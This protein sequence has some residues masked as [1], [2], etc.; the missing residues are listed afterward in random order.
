MAK[1]VLTQNLSEPL[2]G[3]KTAKVDICPGD[4]N[5]IIDGLTCGEPVLASGTLQYLENQELPARSVTTRDGQAELTLRAAGNVRQTWFRMPW[6]ACNGATEWQVHLNP[7]VPSDIT[8]H[9]DGGNVRLD[10]SGMT[11]TRVSADTGGGNVEVILPGS[12]ANLNVIAKTG[13]GGVTVEVGKAT[14]GSSRIDACSG[15]GNVAV[16]LP[17]G[18]AARIYATSG[19][20][21]VIV[22]PRFS[23]VDKTTYQS[24]DYEVAA[25]R[26][27]IT[28]KSGAGNVMIHP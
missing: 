7:G 14:T 20:G 26:V 18:I 2:G 15:A 13:A 1:K 25:D 4:G 19:M 12:A 5:L 8:A 9:S 3:A 27:E 23:Q 28:V 21:K 24:P 17:D 22:E 16:R 6:A 11:V 10:L